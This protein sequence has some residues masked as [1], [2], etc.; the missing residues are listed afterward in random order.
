MGQVVGSYGPATRVTRTTM[1]RCTSCPGVAS[2]CKPNTYATQF[3]D[4]T[5]DHLADQIV[6]NDSGITVLR[7]TGYGIFGPAPEVVVDGP[8]LGRLS[9]RWAHGRQYVLC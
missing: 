1:C 9:H 8:I 3:A 4:V 6:V 2:N 5:N 7:N